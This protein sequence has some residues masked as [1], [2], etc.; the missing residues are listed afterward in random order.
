VDIRGTPIAAYTSMIRRAFLELSRG[1]PRAAR[2]LA[3]Q[4]TE[5]N[6][7]D[8][9]AALAELFLRMH[10]ASGSRGGS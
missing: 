6:P 4:A 1:R 10:T 3:K 7:A 5:S 2:E 8:R 9:A